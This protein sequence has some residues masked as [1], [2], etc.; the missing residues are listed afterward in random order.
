MLSA[1]PPIV[2][3]ATRAPSGAEAVAVTRK[4]A[5]T[6]DG[7]PSSRPERQTNQKTRAA[8]ATA[9]PPTISFSRQIVIR[10]TG[11]LSKREIV[12]H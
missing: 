12:R 4:M 9:A 2:D 7:G 1:I 5:A 6:H 8:E 10:P 3:L 11:W